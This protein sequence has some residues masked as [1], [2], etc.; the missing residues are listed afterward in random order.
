MTADYIGFHAS[1]RPEAVAILD[2]HARKRGLILRIVGDRVVFTPP[3]I[4]DEAE[5]DETMRRWRGA[6]DDTWN[7]LRRAAA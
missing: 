5:V 3:L 2:R 4:I 7:E 6:L 1:E